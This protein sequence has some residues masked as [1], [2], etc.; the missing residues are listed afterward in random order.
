MLY[1]DQKVGG[2]KVWELMI[3]ASIWSLLIG[4]IVWVLGKLLGF[5]GHNGAL[6][7]AVRQTGRALGAK[8]PTQYVE[9]VYQEAQEKNYI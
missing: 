9:P 1:L 4:L 2:L 6:T 8:D 7:A 5:I 3:A